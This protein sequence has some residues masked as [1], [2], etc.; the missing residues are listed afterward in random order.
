MVYFFFYE[1]FKDRIFEILNCFYGWIS[2]VEVFVYK[3]Y[4]RI[5]IENFYWFICVGDLGKDL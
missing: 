3:N 4:V 2:D 5:I 1:G